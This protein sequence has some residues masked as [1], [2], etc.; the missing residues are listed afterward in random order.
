MGRGKASGPDEHHADGPASG[1]PL[2]PAASTVSSQGASE[3]DMVWTVLTVS[4]QLSF[5]ALFVVCFVVGVLCGK[6]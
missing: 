3:E 4:Q 6:T 5:A 2:R 1:L